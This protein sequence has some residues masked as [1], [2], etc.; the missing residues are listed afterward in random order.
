MRASIRAVSSRK[1]RASDTSDRPTANDDERRLFET[2]MQG[3]RPLPQGRG[4]AIPNWDAAPLPTPPEARSQPGPRGL[5]I[6]VNGE[7]VSGA[8]F[9][10]AHELLRDLAAGRVAPEAELNLHHAPADSAIHRTQRFVELSLAQGRRCVLVI[11]GRGQ[12]SGPSGPVLRPAL[13]EA[14]AKK[15]LAN[16][17]L[18]VTTAPPPYGGSGAMLLLLRRKPNQK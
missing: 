12:H 5:R 10:V 13:L 7:T 15:P 6:E 3:V 14:L 18:A 11:H 4:R 8:A 9:G 17:I 2:E 1:G 16:Q